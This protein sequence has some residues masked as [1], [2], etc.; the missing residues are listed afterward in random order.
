VFVIHFVNTAVGSTLCHQ[1]EHGWGLTNNPPWLKCVQKELVSPDYKGKTESEISRPR[2]GRDN[3][4]EAKLRP[5]H[6]SMNECERIWPM[7]ATASGWRRPWAE[8]ETCTILPPVKAAVSRTTSLLRTM[9]AST[10]VC[11]A[12]ALHGSMGH[13]VTA[14]ASEHLQ[15]MRSAFATWNSRIQFFL[16]LDGY[17]RPP[18]RW[19]VQVT[20]HYAFVIVDVGWLTDRRRHSIGHF[21]DDIFI[22]LMTQQSKRVSKHWRRV[23]SHPESRQA[24]LSPGS[25]HHVIKHA[26]RSRQWRRKKI[27]LTH[28][29]QC[30][31]SEPGEMKQ[32]LVDQTCELFK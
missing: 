5:R 24:S 9:H 26:C 1:V 20:V 6:L 32:N 15:T 11:C 2:I 10:T 19:A 18:A 4:D 23:V 12:A 27:N 13:D 3:N 22:C 31:V 21:G 14:V 29:K 25:P 8:T 7:R 28:T 17:F 16:F 30:T